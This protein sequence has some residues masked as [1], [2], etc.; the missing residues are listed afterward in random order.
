MCGIAC[1]ATVDKSKNIKQ[2]VHRM[3]RDIHHRGPD[4]NSVDCIENVGLG[5]ARLAILDLNHTANQPFKDETEEYS[6]IFNG[7]IYN[8]KEIRQELEYNGIKFRTS[9]DTEVLLQAYKFWGSSCV[10]HFNGMW[11]FV[12]HDRRNKRLFCSRDR[13]GEKPMYRYEGKDCI[14]LASEIRQ[15]LPFIGSRVADRVML[16][17]YISGICGDSKVDTF[18]K[19]VKKVPA[20]HN[21]I[22]D[23]KT[24]RSFTER[25][26]SLPT[27]TE[28]QIEIGKD[29]EDIA[30]EFLHHLSESIRIRLRA[31][32]PIA[33]SLSGGLDSSTI[34]RIIC[35]NDLGANEIVAFTAASSNPMKDESSYAQQVAR[36][37]GIKLIRLK[38][39]FRQFDES[40]L[41]VVETQEEP[42]GSA[43]VIMQYQ[44]AKAIAE[45]GFKVAINGQ[46][47]DELL[48]GYERYIPA[49]I[50]NILREKG[51]ICAVK[52]ALQFKKNNALF[53]AVTILAFMV[54]FLNPM[55]R[56]AVI[57]K[58]MKK[59][60]LDKREIN[61]EINTYWN[62]TRNLYELRRYELEKSNLPTLLRFDDKNFMRCS[63]ESRLPFLDPNLVDFIMRLPL[64][65]FFKNGWTK[66]IMRVSMMNRLPIEITRRKDKIGYEAPQHEWMSCYKSQIY[67][68]I[69][70]S[71]IIQ[72][73]FVGRLNRGRL[74]RLDQRLKWRLL[75]ISLWEM[76]FKITNLI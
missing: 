10:N 51:L 76:Q 67:D 24:L 20:G 40:L 26:Y 59:F 66:H 29:E 14:Y 4:H 25:Y 55:I 46:G 48:F 6:L 5:H 17:K 27:N 49:Y 23:L 12:I 54:Y 53:N 13:F 47:A 37:L 7:E 61:K 33:V 31:D 9:S 56:Q 2:I 45:H 43:S 64:D 60:N 74:D 19:C 16:D 69:Q 35:D 36:S 34:L 15:I 18:Y 30:S 1:Y 39:S 75:S 63:V 70:K 21:I 41:S 42:F 52:S 8:Y 38:P 22:I 62:F 58:R 72:D 68:Y 73:C 11:A 44:V 71:D 32:V 50:N 28:A 57:S 65:T 3:M